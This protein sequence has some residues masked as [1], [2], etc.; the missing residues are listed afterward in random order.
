M[1]RT[2]VT[3]GGQFGLFLLVLFLAARRSHRTVE[4]RSGGVQRTAQTRKP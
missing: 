4:V 3:F 2:L 1:K